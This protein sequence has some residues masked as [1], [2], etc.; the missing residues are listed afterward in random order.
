[1]I[2]SRLRLGDLLGRELDFMLVVLACWHHRR[3]ELGPPRSLEPGE[4]GLPERDRSNDDAPRPTEHGYGRDEL[5][6]F[7]IVVGAH[8]ECR[9]GLLAATLCRWGADHCHARNR[10]A[11]PPSGAC[12]ADDHGEHRVVGMKA[13]AFD[14]ATSA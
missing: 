12:P 4:R 10:V 9:R 1:M 11:P 7:L 2:R 5:V 6:D 8:P 13:S 3:L 14:L